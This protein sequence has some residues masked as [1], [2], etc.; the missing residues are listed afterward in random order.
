MAEDEGD[1][2]APAGST[3]NAAPVT[4]PAALPT[5]A[6]YNELVRALRRT[7]DAPEV[8][9]LLLAHFAR[10]HGQGDEGGRFSE[11]LLDRLRKEGAL[12]EDTLDSLASSNNDK[13][14]TSTGAP[15]PRDDSFEVKLRLTDA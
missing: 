9:N 7:A 12:E 3:E 15:S 14:N 10:R 6:E 13:K 2:A 1:S 4:G 5:S 11:A 8:L